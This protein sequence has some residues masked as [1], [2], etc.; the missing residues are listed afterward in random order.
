MA[1]RVRV[2]TFNLYLGADLNILLGQRQPDEIVA[3]LVEVR[4]QLTRTAFPSRV[5]AVARM[6]A[7]EQLDLVGL[8]EACVWQADG[9]PLWDYTSE[10][11][12]ALDRIGEPFEVVLAQPTFRGAGDVPL[13][14]RVAALEL[15]GSNTILRRRGSGVRVRSVRT[16][17]YGQALSMTAMG[18]TEVTIARGWCAA[19]CA[20]EDDPAAVFT[21]IDTHTEAYDRESR[22][23]QRDELVT[24]L[25][26]GDAP[27]VLVGDFN[28]VPEEIGMPRGLQDA[29]IAAGNGADPTDASTCCQAPD[30]SNAESSLTER[31]DYVWVRGVDVVSS[32]RMG[33]EPADQSESGLWPSDHAGVVAEVELRA[34]SGA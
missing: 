27:V 25:P 3:N 9:Q 21:F 7:G 14:G 13:Y 33:A 28:S 6:L 8:Q 24:M 4:R 26:P 31:I 15:S 17:M 23:G 19:D 30:L 34:G 18:D 2:A 5:G 1:S 11:L 16:G 29:W 32:H 10:L 20:P 22:N 12:R